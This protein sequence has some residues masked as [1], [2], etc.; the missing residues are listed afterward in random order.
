MAPI[1]Q[2]Q[3]LYLYLIPYPSPPVMGS[4]ALCGAGCGRMAWQRTRAWMTAVA[5]GLSNSRTTAPG[6]ASAAPGS[7]HTHSDVRASTGRT[8]SRDQAPDGEAMSVTLRAW[9]K[10]GARGRAIHGAYRDRVFRDL[11]RSPLLLGTELGTEVRPLTIA[12]P[13]SLKRAVTAR[14]DN[15]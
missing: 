9:A 6:V 5:R 1:Y 10:D 12:G 11:R 8:L 14:C 7:S 2:N 4:E 13:H 3:S 15:A